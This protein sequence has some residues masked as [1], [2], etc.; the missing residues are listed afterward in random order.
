MGSNVR[1]QHRLETV[2][3]DSDQQLP[4]LAQ[5]SLVEH[6]LCPLDRITDLT[7]PGVYHSGYF[8]TDHDGR[9]KFAEVTVR[10]PG[11]LSP[12]DEYYLWGLL[13]LTFAQPA[14][15]IE[16]W[17]TPH[18]CLRQLG[19]IDR[20][21]GKGGKTY[22]LFR[23]SL[24]RL[25]DVTYHSTAFYNPVRGEYLERKMG[26]LKYEL[27]RDPESSRAWRIV[28]DPLFFEFCQA[29]GGRLF[30]DLE[31][32]RQLDFASRRLFLLLHKIFGGGRSSP[33]FDVRHLAVHTLGF[34]DSVPL[35]AL[36]QKLA[37]TCA[38]LAHFEVIRLPAG[39]R[40][41]AD[42]FLKQSPGQYAIRFEAGAYFERPRPVL[43]PAEATRVVDSPLADPLR[44]IG[45]TN[46]HI[47]QILKEFSP[48]LIQVWSDV[49]LL[50][51]ERQPK[52]FPGFKQSP[53]AFFWH[54]IREAAAKRLTPPDWWHQAKKDEERRLWQERKQ[55]QAVEWETAYR[56]A[57]E[58]A[59]RKFLKDDVGAA[60]YDQARQMFLQLH[61]ARLSPPQA[62]DAARHD[63]DRHFAT[64]FE[65]PDIDHWSP[66]TAA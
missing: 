34:S 9:R 8:Y 39:A 57:R 60:A 53:Q 1:F 35:F 28:W 48:T 41:A 66:Q 11:G 16:L 56:E 40:S 61:E 10:S 19:A 30:F 36:K 17:A 58:T 52:G 44:A 26:F 23:E 47:G 25:A 18:Y 64:R 4:G 5:L 6:A 7:Q 63:A 65:F 14:P 20:A 15:S 42:L 46:R 27:P 22:R 29:T 55:H 54:H 50:A 3:A 37:R 62:Q 12:G 49:T 59:F 13:A 24:D 45:F 43:K 21:A 51:M 32:Y 33:R 38:K 31:L 2:P